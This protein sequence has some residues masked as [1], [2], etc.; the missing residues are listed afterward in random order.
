MLSYHAERIFSTN[1]ETVY[2]ALLREL[3][4]K[5]PKEPFVTVGQYELWIRFGGTRREQILEVIHVRQKTL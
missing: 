2:F 3:T 5:F 4:E 1:D